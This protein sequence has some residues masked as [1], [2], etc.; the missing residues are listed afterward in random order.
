M[1]RAIRF[2]LRA[3]IGVVA[4]AGAL[5]ALFGYFVYSPAP[6]I[7]ELSGMLTRGAFEAD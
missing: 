7:P 2:V 6:E 3:L 4:F 5:A 1:R